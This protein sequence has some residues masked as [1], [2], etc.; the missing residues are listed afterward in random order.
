MKIAI[1]SYNRDPS[2]PSIDNDGA[3]V[4]IRNLAEILS[5]NNFSVD[6]YAN[7][8]HYGKNTDA[9]PDYF[10]KK[11]SLQDQDIVEITRDVRVI[12]V[13]YTRKPV[14]NRKA[15]D[16]LIDIDEI[17][18]SIEIADYY[19]DG[20]LFD[21]DAVLFFHPLSAIGI[22]LKQY[23]AP[24]TSILF[25]MLLSHEYK[26]FMEV[27]ELY[28]QLEQMILDKVGYI[29][30]PTTDENKTVIERVNNSHKAGIIPRGIDTALFHYFEH[31]EIRSKE[32]L[33]LITVG[34]LRK[35][36]RIEWVVEIARKLRDAGI[37][38]KWNIVG[39]NESFVKDEYKRY[40]DSIVKE[41]KSSGLEPHVK[42]IGARSAS[43]ISDLYKTH[44]LAVFTS[45]SE[46]FGKAM[47]EAICCGI[48][49]LLSSGVGAYDDFAET[50]TNCLICESPS[51]FSQAILRLMNDQSLYKHLSVN[52]FRTRK[53][54]DWTNIAEKLISVIHYV[55]GGVKSL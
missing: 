4:T 12:R 37:K 33:K 21:Y 46:S 20:K 49:T 29:S 3:P 55:R 43:E 16:L 44:D 35:Q 15:Y 26:K 10:T 53:K 40:Y 45:A 11:K 6:I 22:L 1:C 17:I 39:E 42:F 52:G 8:I 18:E 38:Y 32:H 9:A 7:R 50:G 31:N 54:Y 19:A 13:D 36:K 30:S 23:V 28:V 14:L 34:S 51:D 24:E 5:K 25:P 48:P 2:I 27:S 47:L 41:I